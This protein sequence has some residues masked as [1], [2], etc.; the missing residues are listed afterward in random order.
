MSQFNAD[1]YKESILA[2]FLDEKYKEQG[3][4]AERIYDKETQKQGIDVIFRG[5]RLDRRVDEKAQLSYLNKSLETFA[6]ELSYF[7]GNT[8][9]QGWLFDSHKLTDGYAFVFDIKVNNTAKTLESV[10]DLVSCEVVFVKRL[11]LLNELA[12]H[13]LNI[14]TCSTFD[15]QLRS[16]AEIELEYP[17]DFRFRI[18]RQLEEVPVNLLVRK[19]FLEAIGKKYVFKA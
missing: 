11:L 12:K 9:K 18:S 6:L 4:Y 10:S 16:S 19:S 7:I 8:Q 5:K 17:D 2:A 3:W 13:E 15:E 14:N 1:L